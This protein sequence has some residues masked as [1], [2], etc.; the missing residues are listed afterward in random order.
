[1]CTWD[2]LNA[3]HKF[4]VWVTILGHVTSL[5]STMMW[6]H[7]SHAGLLVLFLSAVCWNLLSCCLAQDVHHLHRCEAAVGVDSPRMALRYTARQLL[8]LKG[9][10][11][12]AND[13]RAVVLEY[14]DLCVT[15][16]ARQGVVFLCSTSKP[17]A[18]PA[19]LRKPQ[20]LLFRPTGVNF[21]NVSALKRVEVASDSSAPSRLLK[22]ALFNACSV[23]NKALILSD[24]ILEQKLDLVCLTE[25]W[26]KESDG[27]LF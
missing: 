10:L 24:I 3:E 17:V 8:N 12:L 2:G 19:F 9:N 7:A 5:Y 16:I 6:N 14:C 20:R 26:H 13:I 23:N 1:M 21:N 4:R 18:Y 27:L 25:T 15:Y 11:D 22:S